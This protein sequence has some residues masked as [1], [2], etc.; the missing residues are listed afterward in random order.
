VPHWELLK[1]SPSKRIYVY[2]VISG[3]LAQRQIAKVYGRVNLYRNMKNPSDVD[4]LE[5]KL[6]DLEREASHIIRNIHLSLPLGSITLAREQLAT[7]RKFIFVMHYRHDA[8][9][10]TC[11]HEDNPSNASIRDWIQRYKERHQLQTEVDVWLEGLKYYLETPHQTIIATGEDLRERYGNGRFFEMLSKR[12]DPDIEELYAIEY[13]SMANYFFLGVWEAAEDTEFVLSGNGFG[14]WEGLIY[15]NPGAHR[16]YVVSPRIALIL[17]RTCFHQPHSN[18]PSILSSSLAGIPIS[19]PVIKYV[20]KERLTNHDQDNPLLATYRN[21]PEAQKDTFTF[22]FT[23][24]S[25]Q[26]T[27][28]VNGVIM[29]NANQSSITFSRPDAMLSTL[30]V[31]MD[32]HTTFDEDKRS[33]FQPLRVQL[34]QMPI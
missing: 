31:Y 16:I 2:D 19:R 5:H 8:V 11:F 18:D 17:R 27:Y 14:V 24:L 30:E 26:Q 10:T 25:R 21:T 6:A 32:S 34:A 15:G 20:N 4:Y 3:R 1:R 28:A 9:S 12:F 13:E 29:T 33:S 22:T 7:L 23:K